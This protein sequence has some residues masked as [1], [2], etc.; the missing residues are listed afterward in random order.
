MKKITFWLLSAE[1]AFLS[2]YD[3]MNS[4][5]NWAV[6]HSI[7]FNTHIFPA[8][9]SLNN[10]LQKPTMRYLVIEITSKRSFG[11]IKIEFKLQTF[12]GGTVHPEPRY[13]L[14]NENQKS[15][16]RLFWSGTGIYYI[17]VPWFLN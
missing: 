16:V 11:E 8:L 12:G 14:R 7:N 2:Q 15:L 6:V 13:D 1:L 10:G 5:L 17:L 4:H 3:E 9:R